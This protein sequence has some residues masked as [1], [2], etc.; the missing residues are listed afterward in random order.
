MTF[1]LTSQEF[2]TGVWIQ[3]KSA[4]THRIYKAVREKKFGL[5]KSSL[6]RNNI[7]NLQSEQRQKNYRAPGEFEEYVVDLET[8]I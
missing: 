6:L 2:Q 8:D 3:Y 5:V 1:F 7:K 4:M